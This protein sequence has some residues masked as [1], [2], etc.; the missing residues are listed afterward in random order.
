[1][2]AVFQVKGMMCAH[3]E[4]RVI[5]ACKELNGIQSIKASAAE[6][7]VE[8]EFD[9]TKISEAQIKAVIEDVGYDVAE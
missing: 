4:N 6:Q 2:K 8:C 3:C 9:E 1:M 5:Q 7:K